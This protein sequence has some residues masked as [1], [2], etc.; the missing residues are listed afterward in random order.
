M[1]YTYISLQIEPRIKILIYVY[2]M[3]ITTISITKEQ[4]T[5]LL[6]ELHRIVRDSLHHHLYSDDFEYECAKNGGGRALGLCGRVTEKL[7]D[8]LHTEFEK[9]FSENTSDLIVYTI[10]LQGFVAFVKT[11]TCS[12]RWDSL[13]EDRTKLVDT[14]CIY[15]EKLIGIDVGHSPTLLSSFI[16][17]IDE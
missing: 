16:N 15:V 3:D 5:T 14:L 9:W 8:S 7:M 13:Y 10:I 6:N 17:I 4:Y 2:K 12:D 1:V 11:L